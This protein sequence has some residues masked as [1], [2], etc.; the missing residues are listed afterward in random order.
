MKEKYIQEILKLADKAAK[1]DEIPVGAIVVFN[2]SIIA[3]GYNKREKNNRV[4]DHAEII[5]IN[6]ASKKLKTWKLCD[7]DMY[8]TL[9]PCSM[10]EEV[11]KQSRIKNVYYLLDKL[12][13]KKEY[14]KTK[15]TLLKNND[16]YREKMGDFFK[17]MRN[18]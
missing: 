9:K 5:A 16:K 14:N 1:K 13:Y 7:C 10:C 8:V 15:F 2:G 4:I 12:D 11:I 17:K 6:K 3:K 18:K